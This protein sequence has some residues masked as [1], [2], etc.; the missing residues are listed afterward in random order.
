[1]KNIYV[2]SV[3]NYDRYYS[4]INKA[5]KSASTW[6][7][8]YTTEM[9]IEEIKAEVKEYNIS[10]VGCMAD[11]FNGGLGTNEFGEISVII[12]RKKIM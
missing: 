2:L 4:N 1:M 8:D 6:E 9:N 12:S 3:G 10:L 11:K 5:I 7:E